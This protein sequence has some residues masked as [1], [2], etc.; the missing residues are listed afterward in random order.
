MGPLNPA[1]LGTE[2]PPIGAVRS[3][4]D[5]VDL[6]YPLIDL[7]QAA[8]AASPPR[9]LRRA[10]ADWVLE[11]PSA[12]LYAPVLGLPDL[13]A[14]IAKRWSDLYRGRIADSQVAI[15]SGCNQAFAAAIQTL[16]SHGDEVI[17]PCPWYFNHKMWCDMAGLRAVPLHVGPDL[18][19]DPDRAATLLTDRTKALVL[20]SPNNPCGV[21]YPPALLRAF[22]DLA[23]RHGI[24]LILDETYR[25]FHSAAGAPHDLFQRD[26]DTHL[27]HL[28]SFSKAY[29]L[30]GHRVGAIVT[31]P[32]RIAQVEKVLDTVSICATPLGQMAALWGLRHLGDWLQAERLEILARRDAVTA[33]FATLPGWDLRG[34]GAYFAWVDGPGAATPLAKRL[35][36]EAGLLGL[37]GT[38]FAPTKTDHAAR[39]LRLAFAN[40]DRPQLDEVFTRLRAFAT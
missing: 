6:P 8:P 33:G 18:L 29:R 5:G 4:L 2:A 15:T 24:A 25:D 37:P 13:R 12:H 1:L 39:A 17:L 10:M 14:A 9:Q 36:S 3:W 26:W 35:L 21:A 34:C 31:S 32:Q 30:T 11:T 23:A 19:P 27:I 38:M 40:C 20:V 16:A 22:A 28:Y 7:S